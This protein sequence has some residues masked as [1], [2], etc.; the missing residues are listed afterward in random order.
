MTS[1]QK[2]DTHTR[3][4][5]VVSLIGLLMI[6]IGIILVIVGAYHIGYLSM[7]F[8]KLS[9]DDFSYY[10]TMG[11]GFLAP[12]MFIL[13]PGLYLVFLA[14]WGKLAQYA[15]EEGGRAMSK[16]SDNA[17]NGF[18]RIIGKGSEAMATGIQNAGGVKFDIDTNK[19]QVIKIKCR[20]CG[21]LNDENAKFCD[22]CGQPI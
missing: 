9:F 13:I 19:E 15:Y 5:R 14:N 3:K 20:A 2:I 4:R 7:N 22:Q 18:G 11:F 16:V 21:T 12:G 17:I 8:F 1:N 10:S 6:I